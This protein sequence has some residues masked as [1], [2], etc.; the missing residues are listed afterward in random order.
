MKITASVRLPADLDDENISSHEI[1]QRQ[2]DESEPR[3]PTKMS[4]ILLKFK[5]YLLAS[6]V[7]RFAR[8]RGDLNALNELDRRISKE[9]REHEMRFTDQQLP[10]YHLAH[11]YILNNYTH[12]L[13]LILHRN[14]LQ[15]HEASQDAGM[16]LQDQI[17]RSRA[18]CRTSAITLLSNYD[19]LCC[20]ERF[21]PYRW[22]AYGL[23]SFQAFLAASTMVVLLDIDQDLAA[24]YRQEFLQALHKCQGLFEQMAARSDVSSKAALILGRLLRPPV[25]RGDVEQTTLYHQSSGTN[26]AES[27]MYDRRATVN[28]VTAMSGVSHPVMGYEGET[29]QMDATPFIS[30]PP[31]MYDLM[32]LPPEQWLG[33]ASALAWDWNG[34]WLEVTDAQIHGPNSFLGGPGVMM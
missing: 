32:G 13:R 16:Q 26:A 33:G 5:L 23:G 9:E 34:S 19:T 14:Y 17:L 31:Q 8:E 24:P 10:V 7:C 3:P 4:Y 22:F 12:Y 1:L 28:H 29:K 18:Y 11:Q 30:C 25:R 15:P 6:D 20:S 2:M 27:V 21:K